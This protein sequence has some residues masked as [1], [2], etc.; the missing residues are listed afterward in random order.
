MANPRK[1]RSLLYFSLL[2]W[3]IGTSMGFGKIKNTS[4]S[5][6]LWVGI[7]T[8]SSLG[9]TLINTFVGYQ[10]KMWSIFTTIGYGRWEAFQAME[11]M[12]YGFREI[13]SP[14]PYQWSS[15]TTITLGEKNLATSIEIKSRKLIV[16]EYETT[17]IDWCIEG[18]IAKELWKA[19]L[20]YGSDL[21]QGEY[22]HGFW[23]LRCLWQGGISL[24]LSDGYQITGIL[25]IWN[26]PHDLAIGWSTILVQ[27]HEHKEI[28][29]FSWKK[30]WQDLILYGTIGFSIWDAGSFLIGLARRW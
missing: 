2:W 28:A 19:T 18:F 16:G 26:R 7:E 23:W 22:L 12:D 13:D 4:L 27:S 24:Q 8:M 14:I 29:I 9:Y 6:G 10:Q 1:N 30:Q 21:F 3:T 25:W 17:E 15:H 5:N 20:A 11:A